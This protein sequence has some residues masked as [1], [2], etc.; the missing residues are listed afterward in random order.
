MNSKDGFGEQ[1]GMNSSL[2]SLFEELSNEIKKEQETNIL[3]KFKKNLSESVYE[4]KQRN[5]IDGFNPFNSYTTN[6]TSKP[7]YDEPQNLNE[8]IFI[9]NDEI[10]DKF[11]FSIFRFVFSIITYYVIVI[12]G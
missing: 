1:K 12:R 2:S 9:I 11:I 6:S 8:E 4:I 7:I 10:E 5:D 3:F